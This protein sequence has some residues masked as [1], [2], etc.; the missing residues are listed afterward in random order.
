MTVQ[1][2]DFHDRR[3]RISSVDDLYEQIF[4]AKRCVYQLRWI[5]KLA[6]TNQEKCVALRN[7]E[8]AENVVLALYG[9][10]FDIEDEIALELTY[11]GQRII[12]MLNA[13]RPN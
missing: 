7:V 8:L 10:C 3:A 13:E 11:Q 4:Q 9:S 2:L 6:K 5:D 12:P 1:L